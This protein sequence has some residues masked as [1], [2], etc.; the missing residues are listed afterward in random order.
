MF[1]LDPPRQVQGDS[2]DTPA[3]RAAGCSLVGPS[4]HARGVGCDDA[5]AWARRDDWLVACVSDGAGSARFGAVGSDRAVRSISERIAE[6]LPDALDS[7]CE[8]VVAD[9]VDAAR[10]QLRQL[11][12]AWGAGLNDFHATLVG[13]IM[14]GRRA[15][16]FHIGD[17]A[18]AALRKDGAS[19]ADTALSPPQNGE[20]I[21]ETY[22]L[23]QERWRDT[24]RFTPVES[25]D[26]LLLM[27][28]GVTPFALDR[29][30]AAGAG[31]FLDP[32]LNTLDKLAPDIAER[33]LRNLL[34]RAD[35]RAACDD[36]KT[37][38]WVSNGSVE[39]GS[40]GEGKPDVEM[41]E[42][43]LDVRF[44][45]KRQRMARRGGRYL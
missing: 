34:A 5:F 4:H 23:T 1:E 21:N 9:A 7:R 33:A 24:L 43:A 26:A 45:A 29:T 17:G 40:G 36:D 35:V 25:F 31:A 22:F 8:Q 20:Y 10:E 27:T 37:L 42:V 3:W 38:L 2:L 32:L 19:W 13:A 12:S 44:A 39:T 14:K 11:A 16:L 30:R 41:K 28:D 15:L 6:R 18:A